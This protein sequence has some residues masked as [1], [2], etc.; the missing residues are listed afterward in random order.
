MP[1][2]ASAS[3]AIRQDKKRAERNKE[4][5]VQI[6]DLS[7]HFR[8]ALEAKDKTQA[9]KLIKDLITAIDKASQRKVLKRNTAARKKSRL[10][11]RL[12]QLSK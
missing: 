5:L 12:N 2:K 11:K 1:N 6:R 7:R 3:K 10:M 9:E 8:K 4:K